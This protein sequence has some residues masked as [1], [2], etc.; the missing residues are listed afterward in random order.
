MPV[1]FQKFTLQGSF[2]TRVNSL[3]LF[4]RSVLTVLLQR[5]RR[6]PLRPSWPLELEVATHF[7]RAQDAEV[8][9]LAAHASMDDVRAR[10][11]SLVFRLPP[12]R[13]LRK[14]RE[15]N[16][17]GVWF[18]TGRPGPTILYF[19]GGGYAFYPAMTDNIIASVV[20]AVGGNSFIPSYRLTPEH[21]YPA[22]FEDAL[23]A[24]RWLIERGTDP[25]RLVVAG[26][27][28]GGHLALALLL[29]LQARGLPA[30]AAGI[31]ISPWTDPQNGGA[32]MQTNIGFDWMSPPMSDRLAR[33]AGPEFAR[34]S[35]VQWPNSAD[36]KT[37]PPTLVHA[38]EAEICRD[39]IATFCANAAAAG[40][41]ITYRCW[42]DMTHNFQGFGELVPQSRQ[43]LQEIGA[44]IAAHLQPHRSA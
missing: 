2:S 26:D 36:F 27:S 21:P 6:R 39:M 29:S 8:L 35:L 12:L 37:L 13:Q 10:V 9:R 33:W 7:F 30:P 31:A 28:A 15:D 41:P 24:Y 25:S 42:E 38:G 20:M 23:A 22:Q 18:E 17:P 4:L 43:A 19:H 5:A 11:D 14:I 34:A 3:G 16:P 40:A 1:R 44:F 32:S